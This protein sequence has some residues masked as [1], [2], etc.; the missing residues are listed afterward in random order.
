MFSDKNEGHGDGEEASVDIFCLLSPLFSLLCAAQEG[1]WCLSVGLGGN[2]AS[3][4]G[5]LASGNLTIVPYANHPKEEVI[6]MNRPTEI[7]SGHNMQYYSNTKVK[8]HRRQNSGTN[9]ELGFLGCILEGSRQQSIE[10]EHGHEVRVL[11]TSLTLLL[12][13]FWH[14]A[15]NLICLSFLF[16]FFIIWKMGERN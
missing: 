8:C 12:F 13:C 7:S 10:E 4:G 6:P 16:Y 3:G 14:P 15:G 1:L 5:N 11:T 2:L 9:Q